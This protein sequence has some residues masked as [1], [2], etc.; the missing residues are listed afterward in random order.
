MRSRELCTI[1]ISNIEFRIWKVEY[2]K[3]TVEPLNP[4]ILES[5]LPNSWEKNQRCLRVVQPDEGE[6]GNLSEIL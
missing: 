1:I 4:G 5:F 6:N 3:Q 2:G